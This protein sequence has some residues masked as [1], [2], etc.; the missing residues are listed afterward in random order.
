MFGGQF[1]A[2]FET[3]CVKHHQ[4]V[5]EEV[6]DFLS[7]YLSAPSEHHEAY[8]TLRKCLPNVQRFR[9]ISLDT[10]CGAD[11]RTAI[12]HARCASL[13]VDWDSS[14]MRYVLKEF[15]S[16]K[17]LRVAV[18]NQLIAEG[19]R[20]SDVISSSTGTVAIEQ[21]TDI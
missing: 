14:S 12:S 11:S 4:E 9:P 13:L 19:V 20:V 16:I 7:R 10:A 15:P 1:Q 21:A 5:H 17:Q 2:L 3:E 18:Q 8:A 6:L